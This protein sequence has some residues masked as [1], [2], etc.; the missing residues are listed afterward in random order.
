MSAGRNSGGMVESASPQSDVTSAPIIISAG[1]VGSCAASSGC[2]W[3]NH[4]NGPWKWLST[5]MTVMR[6]PY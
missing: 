6:A 5:S 1:I 3:S 2:S 4:V